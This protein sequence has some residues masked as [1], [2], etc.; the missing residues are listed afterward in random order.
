MNKFKVISFYTENGPYGEMSKKLI[1]SCKRFE[2]DCDIEKYK[3]RSSWVDNC[4]IKPE[5]ILKK[6]NEDVDCVVWIDC[7][8]R[9]MSYPYLFLDTPMD[10]GV[11]GELGARKKTPA[12]REEIE[13]PKNWPA[14]TELMWFNSGTIF[15]RKCA[16]TIRMVESWLYYSLNMTRSW[17]Q[18]SL[19][20]AWSDSQPTTEWLPRPY[21]QI[22]RMHGRDKAVVL[23]D[24]ASVIQ[25]VNRK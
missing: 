7:D 16:S 12:G 24:L 25:K 21:C 11:R 4:N 18:W 3:D 15:F 5:F 9:I 1:E 6:L 22:D 17:D 8:A 20:Q 13:L 14:N 19:Q 23:H 2:I 10:F